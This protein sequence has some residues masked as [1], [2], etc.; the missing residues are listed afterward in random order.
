MSS[1]KQQSK[2]GVPAKRR[3]QE[4]G[5]GSSGPDKASIEKEKTPALRGRRKEANK[6]FADNSSQ[7]VGSD[8]ALPRSNTPSLPA[9][10][11]TGVKLGESGGE[12]VFK[13]RQAQKSK[14]K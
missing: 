2:A 3:G 13:R 9:A 14:R 1:R 5:D 7:Q 8:S 12:T 10:L 11:P 6:M 4:M